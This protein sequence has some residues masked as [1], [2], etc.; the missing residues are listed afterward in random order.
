MT[1]TKKNPTITSDPIA[2]MLTKHDDMLT[3]DGKDA[4][5]TSLRRAGFGNVLCMALDSEKTRQAFTIVSGDDIRKTRNLTLDA[6]L[7]AAGDESGEWRKANIDT[8]DRVLAWNTKAQ[9]NRSKYLS[10]ATHTP[11]SFATFQTCTDDVS[12]DSYVL[13]VKLTVSDADR[14]TFGVGKASKLNASRSFDPAT[15]KLTKSATTP[16]SDADKRL[17]AT[18]RTNQYGAMP[19]KSVDALAIVEDTAALPAEFLAI[20]LDSDVVSNIKDIRAMRD[21]LQAMTVLNVEDSTKY[22]VRKVAKIIG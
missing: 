3:A 18:K 21:F 13:W 4:V 8:A 22:S 16:V 7:A 12:F 15:K 2:Y 10:M 1:T 20:M 5:S 19:T 17:A 6:L 11:E 9:S 14:A